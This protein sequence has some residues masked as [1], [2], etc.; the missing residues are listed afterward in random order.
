MGEYILS[1]NRDYSSE[2]PAPEMTEVARIVNSTNESSYI[3]IVFIGN[4]YPESPWKIRAIKLFNSNKERIPVIAIRNEYLNLLYK[5]P[6]LFQTIALHETGHI[7]NGDL[8]DEDRLDTAND[9][10][11]TC[12]FLGLVEP[13]EL[14]ADRFSVEQVGK[15]AVMNALDYLIQERKK[16]PYDPGRELAIKEFENRK[17][18][19]KKL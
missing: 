18:A 15:S 4:S 8:D 16:R 7:L 13:H 2:S 5:K 12:V 3:P 1:I 9:A 14:N 17:K 11:T 6:I 10:R 19:I